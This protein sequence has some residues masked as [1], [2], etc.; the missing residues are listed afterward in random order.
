M[1]IT[2]DFNAPDDLRAVIDER[3][4]A[5]TRDL[6]PTKGK[7][8]LVTFA[9][10]DDETGGCRG[11]LNAVVYGHWMFVEG[12][13]IDEDL[14]GQQFGTHLLSQAE[15]KAR[16]MDLVGIWLDTFDFQA[17]D[18]Y[19]KAGFERFGTLKDYPRGH[20]RCFYQKIL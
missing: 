17:P 19:E 20:E 3:L 5:Y 1:S 16:A 18:F 7:L 12:L 13:F 10:I 4:N 11:G 2:I 9:L 8:Q 14:R 15:D 6:S